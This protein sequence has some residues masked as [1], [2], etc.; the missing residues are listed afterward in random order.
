MK[1]MVEHKMNED[2]I[3][4]LSEYF[5]QRTAEVLEEVETSVKELQKKWLYIGSAACFGAFG[6]GVV[7]GRMTKGE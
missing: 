3:N 6:I 5:E 1:I 4:K 7:I 2:Q